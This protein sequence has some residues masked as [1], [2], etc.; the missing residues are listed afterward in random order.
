MKNDRLNF[1]HCSFFV[2][3]SSF[4]IGLHILVGA[5]AVSRSR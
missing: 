1:F 5:S 4:F 2:V 3:R